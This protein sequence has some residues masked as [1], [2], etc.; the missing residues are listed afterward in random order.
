MSYD[1][2]IRMEKLFTELKNTSTIY[3]NELTEK[4]IDVQVG[5]CDEV[6]LR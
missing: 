1:T 5:T 6:I 2:L 3:Y 4:L